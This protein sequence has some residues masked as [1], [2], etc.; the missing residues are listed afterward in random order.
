MRMNAAYAGKSARIAAQTPAA[1]GYAVRHTDHDIQYIIIA[2]DVH[3]D[4]SVQCAGISRK[5]LQ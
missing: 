2:A 1:Q 5:D 4:L 3:G